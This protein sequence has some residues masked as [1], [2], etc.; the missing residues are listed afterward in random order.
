[1]RF[2]RSLYQV[3]GIVGTVNFEHIKRHYY[4]SHPWLDPTGIVPTGPAQDFSQPKIS[5]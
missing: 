1:L 3:P 2:T 4:L 5:Y